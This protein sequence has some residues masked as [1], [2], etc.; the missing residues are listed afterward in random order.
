M[1]I[2]LRDVQVQQS[3]KDRRFEEK[4]NVIRATIKEVVGEVRPSN[5]PD[6]TWIAEFGMPG[7]RALVL[8]DTTLDVPELEVLVGPDPR[9][10]FRRVI[11]PYNGG[12]YDSSGDPTGP[13]AV[14]N[15]APNHQMP[16]E[17]N[18]GL[19]PVKVYQPAIQPLKT[20]GD[21]FTLTVSTQAYKYTYN[22]QRRLFPGAQTDISGYVPA[23]G[24]VNILIYL[25]KQTNLLEVITGTNV[26]DLPSIPTPFP[27]LPLGD[28]RASAWVRLAYGQTSVTTYP[29]IDDAR[30]I[31]GGGE[32]SELQATQVGQILISLD[33]STFEARLPLL[34]SNGGWISNDEGLM[35]L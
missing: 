5:R 34:S 21:G 30:E 14:P 18:I 11:G 31:L 9:P 15:H 13:L 26:P 12:S 3:R 4:R 17:D 2:D 23:S 19:D 33:G 32:V 20:T 6:L 10:P 29:D 24:A 35:V 1:P 27:A 22:R 8:N 28:H 7:S 25:N 16:S